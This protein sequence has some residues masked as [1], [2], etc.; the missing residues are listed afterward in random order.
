M[1]DGG[2]NGDAQNINQV[3]NVV[4]GAAALVRIGMPLLHN[5]F[6]VREPAHDQQRHA[7]NRC[8]PQV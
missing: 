4:F 2:Q 1:R 7:E 8:I 3:L 5:E 6:V